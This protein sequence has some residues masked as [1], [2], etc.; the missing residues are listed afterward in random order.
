MRTNLYAIV[1]MGIAFEIIEVIIRKDSKSAKRTDY[2]NMYV[3]EVM[4]F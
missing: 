3:N 4:R 2:G 1:L